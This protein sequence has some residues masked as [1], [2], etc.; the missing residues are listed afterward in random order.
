MRTVICHYHIYKNSGTT[1]DRILTRN[2]GDRHLCFDGPFPY[3]SINQQELLKV[4]Q[5]NPDVVAFSS[6]QITLPVPTALDINVLP[7]V[8]V[9][10]PLL[11]IQSIYSFKRAEKDGTDTSRNAEQMAFDEWCRH[12]LGHPREVTLVS[13]A[14][15]RMLGA[16]TGESA[17]A[18]RTKTGMVYDFHQALR[19]LRTVDLL[20]R[21]EYF[22]ADVGRF[23]AL[24]AAH[25]I[26]LSVEDTTPANVTVDDLGKSLQERL[27]QLRESVPGALYEALVAA[28]EQD[29]ALY[30][31]ACRRLD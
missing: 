5:R 17:L 28:N 31:Q 15:T 12:C 14:Q 30:E 23:P 22:D 3:F 26:E 16:V 24:L 10:H 1:F 11:R 21:T 27:Q 7:A 6:H 18:Q 8:F 20:A 2:F 9:R 29:L 25:G 4:I 19:N 13:N